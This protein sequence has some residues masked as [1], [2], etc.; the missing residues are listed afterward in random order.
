MLWTS[1]LSSSC[2]K[3]VYSG[4][5]GLAG[6]EGPALAD[7]ARDPVSDVGEVHQALDSFV[8]EDI[9]KIA[10]QVGDRAGGA[11]VGGYPEG[12]GSCSCRRFP[13]SRGALAIR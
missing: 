4:R 3:D 10:V 12:V 8:I 1:S 5:G 2:L 6:V 11:M 13:A 9:P 7:G